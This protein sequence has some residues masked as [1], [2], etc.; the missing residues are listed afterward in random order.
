[1]RTI[2][3]LLA[4][5][6]AGLLAAAGLIVGAQDAHA[7]T[8]HN[9]RDGVTAGTLDA[10]WVRAACATTYDGVK[11]ALRFPEG[12][13]TVV[14]EHRLGGKLLGVETTHTYA[15]DHRHGPAPTR[16]AG[17]RITNGVRVECAAAGQRVECVLEYAR[18][19]VDLNVTTFVNGW[20]YGGLR[21]E[22]V[23]L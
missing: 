7:D 2:A 17:G 6:I 21:G 22:G 10:G 4:P 12:A 5:L 1:M 20:N 8:P 9:V 14:L 13:R 16:T 15:D 19:Y 18:R 11:C 3:R 23:V